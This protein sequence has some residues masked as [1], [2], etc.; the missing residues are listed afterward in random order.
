M[1][2]N[3]EVTINKPIEEVST[4]LQD[5]NHFDKWQ[6]GFISHEPMEGQPGAVGSKTK[7]VY[8]GPGNKNFDLIETIEV[9]NWPEEFRGLYEAKT[10]VNTMT[11]KLSSVGENQT[12]YWAEVEYT[13][14]NGC[15]PKLM[16]MLAPK[17]FKRQVQKWMDQFK[18]FAEEG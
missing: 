13:R 15:I 14:F 1:K 8:K 17:M 4:L 12:R 7:L 9:A 16:A 2:F 18:A 5:P 6:D 10:M 3:C 11:T